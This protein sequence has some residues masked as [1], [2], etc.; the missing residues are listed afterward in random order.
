MNRYPSIEYRI[1]MNIE[2]QKIHY[3]FQKGIG[4]SNEVII[5]TNL[6]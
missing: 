1:S 5:L 6:L 4:Y 2:L 3:H